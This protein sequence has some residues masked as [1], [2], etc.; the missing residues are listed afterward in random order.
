[1]KDKT[2]EQESIDHLF[3]APRKGVYEK[4]VVNSTKFIAEGKELGNRIK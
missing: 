2:N 3:L 1:L 4:G